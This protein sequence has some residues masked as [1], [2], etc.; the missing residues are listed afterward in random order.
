MGNGADRHWPV[1]FGGPR[2][3]LP[4]SGVGAIEGFQLQRSFR[5]EEG[6]EDQGES[7]GAAEHG[8]ENGAVRWMGGTG[9]WAWTYSG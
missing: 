4:E 6:R 2:E 5:A 7:E 8:M 9:G 3:W 1:D